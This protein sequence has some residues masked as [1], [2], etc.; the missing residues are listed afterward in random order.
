MKQTIL[1]PSY[2]I[3]DAGGRDVADS[4]DGPCLSG[5]VLKWALFGLAMWWLWSATGLHSMA[6]LIGLAIAFIVVSKELRA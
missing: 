6:W 4:P 5:F 1:N 3:Q 2:T